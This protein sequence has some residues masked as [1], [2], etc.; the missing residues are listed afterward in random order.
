M[1]TI[2]RTKKGGGA[3]KNFVY[4]N[5]GKNLT[6]YRPKLFRFTKNIIKSVTR[7][8]RNM[9]LKIEYN[10]KQANNIII[11]NGLK[12]FSDQVIIEPNLLLRAS[13]RHL[14]ILYDI[15]HTDK[16][17]TIKPYLNWCCAM[18]NNTKT[19]ISIINYKQP[20]PIFGTHRFRFE[21]YLYPKQFNLTV[22]NNNPDDR[23]KTYKQIQKYIQT[24]KLVKRFS[25][26][27]FVTSRRSVSNNL[28]SILSKG[29]SRK[30]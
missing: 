2:K 16:M 17:K 8:N 13:A 4:K 30:L 14:L 21:L 25:M 12:V 3:F 19:G 1:R 10:Y 23:M 22:I 29:K 24:N 26:I 18:Q 20:N 6:P 11:K 7:N 15:D 9:F 5:L 28:I 27:F